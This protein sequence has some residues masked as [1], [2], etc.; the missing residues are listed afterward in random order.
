MLPCNR[1]ARLPN[2]SQGIKLT[3]AAAP[4]TH[5]LKTNLARAALAML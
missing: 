2:H 5:G 3:V 1:Q 4:T